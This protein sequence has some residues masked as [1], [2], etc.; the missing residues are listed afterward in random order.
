MNGIRM[1]RTGRVR[2]YRIARLLYYLTGE[3]N[4]Q[5]CVKRKI[6]QETADIR[7]STMEKTTA[8]F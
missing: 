1:D 4:R 7:Y 5:E 6:F 3:M 2:L 8:E